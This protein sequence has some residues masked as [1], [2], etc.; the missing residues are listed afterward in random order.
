MSTLTSVHVVLLDRELWHEAVD[1][2]E[3]AVLDE[4]GAEVPGGNE[5]GSSGEGGGCHHQARCH[6]RQDLTQQVHGPRNR[7][8][9]CV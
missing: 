7:I 4:D 2:Q 3:E 9:V 5:D 8:Q 6:R 1:L